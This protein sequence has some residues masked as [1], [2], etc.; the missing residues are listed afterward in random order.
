MKIH[1]LEEFLCEL[2]GFQKM[3]E[4]ANR[5]LVRNRF[6]AEIDTG[7]APHGLH[8]IEGFFYTPVAEVKPVLEKVEPQAFSPNLWEDVPFPLSDRRVLE[9]RK[10]LSKGLSVPFRRERV[11]V[12]WVFDIS[13][14]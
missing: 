8:V 1:R 5:G 7:E 14:T 2:V 9:E 10:A 11:P 12:L 6:V 3:A 4:L 13:R